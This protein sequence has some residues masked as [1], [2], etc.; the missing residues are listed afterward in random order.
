MA[1]R[2][3]AAEVTMNNRSLRAYTRDSTVHMHSA[4]RVLTT[5]K[6]QCFQLRSAPRKTCVHDFYARKQLLLSARLSHRNSVRPSVRHTGG[7]GQNGP[8]KLGSPN[9]HARLPGELLFQEP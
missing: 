1:I 5:P 2:T 4:K 7:S 9:L 6:I 3:S 8:I